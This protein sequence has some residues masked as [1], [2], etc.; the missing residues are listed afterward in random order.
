MTSRSQKLKSARVG[1]GALLLALSGRG[2]RPFL[3]T[4]KTPFPLAVDLWSRPLRLL[5]P[6]RRRRW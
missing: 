6:L 2:K 1:L 4:L 5:R 3:P